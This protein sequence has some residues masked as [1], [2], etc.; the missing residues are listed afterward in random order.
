[1]KRAVPTS[2]RAVT[3]TGR[4]VDYGSGIPDGGLLHNWDA[5]QQS[6]TDGNSGNFIDT[7]GSKDLTTLGGPT[8]RSSAV[9][10]LPAFE[11]DG[12]GDG[13]RDVS[14]ARL[15][16]N[17]EYTFATVFALTGSYPGHGDAEIIAQNGERGDGNLHAVAPSRSAY[18][19]SHWGEPNNELGTPDTNAHILIS[20]YDGTDVTLWLDTA[21]QTTITNYGYPNSPTAFN[22]GQHD[23][24]SR[25][26]ARAFVSH[27]LHYD[28]YYDAAQREQLGNSLR[29]Y[30]SF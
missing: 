8:F 27:V 25:S 11:Y 19:Q 22:V 1:M 23:N 15:G 4:S 30:W 9:N 29:D 2:S 12:S 17:N 6:L 13:H 21:D 28:Q 5:Q 7:K 20:A 16:T 18:R 3:T 24:A 26:Q 10:G 14:G